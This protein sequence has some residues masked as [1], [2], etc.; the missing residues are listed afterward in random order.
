M[1]RLIELL[2]FL[3]IVSLW[4]FAARAEAYPTLQDP[5]EYVAVAYNAFGD[6]ILLLSNWCVGDNARQDDMHAYRIADAHGNTVGGGCWQMTN[7]HDGM[8]HY[9]S[10]D[11]GGWSTWPKTAFHKPF[12]K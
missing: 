1:K 5:A 9:F 7:R 8:I 3:G 2:A 10:L 12:W 6:R 4:L 11:G